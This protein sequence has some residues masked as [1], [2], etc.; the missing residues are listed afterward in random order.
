MARLRGT[1]LGSMSQ[2][3]FEDFERRVE[4]RALEDHLDRHYADADEPVDPETVPPD[5]EALV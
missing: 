5:P 4:T 2:A 1:P 3:D